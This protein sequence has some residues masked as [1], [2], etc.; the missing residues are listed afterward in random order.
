M[1]TYLVGGA[2]RDRLLGIDVIERDWVVVGATGNDMLARGLRRV[3]RDFPV[4]LDPRSGDQYALA[5]RERKSGHGYAGFEF[6]VDAGVSLEDDLGRR[7]L[8]INAIAED[9]D[10]TLID[11]YGGRADLERGVLRHVSDAFVEDPLRVLRVA[12]F[13]A[14]FAA[15]GFIIAPETLA[16]M[17]EIAASGEL[18]HLV[19]ERVWEETR[20]ALGETRPDVFFTTLRACGALATVFP[21]IER[22]FGVPQTPRHHPEID[23][24]IHILLCLQ[25]A[26]RLELAPIVRFALLT[27]DLG[28]AL[29]PPE[30]W[31]S[32][33]GHERLGAEAVRALCTRLRVPVKWRELAL[34][35]CLHHTRCHR[36]LEMR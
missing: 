31:P 35:V 5:R 22:L 30:K 28:K 6:E 21:E 19:A 13:A 32:H 20:R 29:T 23:T 7:D 18:D 17:R 26:A 4:F 34:L 3:G 27:H 2:V 25:L 16:L 24:G 36:A 33:I 10:G 9:L 12:R 11:P 14:R 15:R 1:K 8:T